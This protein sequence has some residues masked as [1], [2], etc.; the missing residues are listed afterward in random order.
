MRVTPGVLPTRFSQLKG[1]NLFLF[2]ESSRLHV[3]LTV[4]D[5][6]SNGDKLILPIG[7]NLPRGMK[8][9]TLLSSQALT[10]VSFGGE[11]TLRLP[12]KPDSWAIS[13]PKPEIQSVLVVGGRPYFRANF[14]PHEGNFRACFVD[15]E[16]GEIFSNRNDLHGGYIQ[17]AGPTAFAIEWEIVT[18]EDEPRPIVIFLR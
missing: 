4:V 3:A 5:P 11:F 9:P 18:A 12:T 16:S 15:M 14:S 2:E 7:S 10:V 8:W 13:E 1:G 17:P 6:T